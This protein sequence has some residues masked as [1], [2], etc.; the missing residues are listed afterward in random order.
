MAH[1]M[2]TK[3]NPGDVLNSSEVWDVSNKLSTLAVELAVVGY[4]DTARDLVSLLNTYYPLYPEHQKR[5]KPLW[6][7]WDITSWPEGEKEKV[8]EPLDHSPVD[9]PDCE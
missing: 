7:A 4:F 6:Y 1:I 3:F 2:T 8:K 5:L 9:Y